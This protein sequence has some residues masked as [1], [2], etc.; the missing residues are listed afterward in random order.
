M[1][2][3]Y[4]EVLTSRAGHRRGTPREMPIASSLVAT[5]SI[6][7]LR[8]YSQIPAKISLETLDGATTSTLRE[9]DNAVYFTQEQFAAGLH[10]PIPSLVKQF[11]HFTEHLLHSYI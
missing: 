1:E 4:E 11:L 6:E 8:L 3:G 2:R 10:L 5:M 9:V 7:K